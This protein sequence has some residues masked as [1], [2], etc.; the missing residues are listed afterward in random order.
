MSDKLD[1]EVALDIQKLY[2]NKLD[3]IRKM[4]VRNIGFELVDML[5]ILIIADKPSKKAVSEKINALNSSDDIAKE[6]INL[7]ENERPILNKIKERFVSD[8]SSLSIEDNEFKYLK[9][10]SAD[11]QN[12]L[13]FCKYLKKL[14]R[15]KNKSLLFERLSKEYLQKKEEQINELNNNIDK[16]VREMT[17]KDIYNQDLYRLRTSEDAQKQINAIKQ[18]KENIDSNGNFKIN[19]N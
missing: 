15:P 9:S 2:M 14:D 18:A 11:S 4:K 8:I 6:L 17:I 7:L 16:I 12:L 3:I 5:Y 13:K 10:Q 19:I 1:K